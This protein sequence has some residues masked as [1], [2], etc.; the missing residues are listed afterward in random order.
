MSKL[1][2]PPSEAAELLDEILKQPVEIGVGERSLEQCE[3]AQRDA[4]RADILKRGGFPVIGVY[5]N[6]PLDSSAEK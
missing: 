5:N 1:P 6:R 2:P 3:K 4:L